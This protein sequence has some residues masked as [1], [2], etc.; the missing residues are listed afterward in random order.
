MIWIFRGNKALVKLKVQTNCL[1]IINGLLGIL[2][3]TGFTVHSMVMDQLTRILYPHPKLNFLLRLVEA[4]MTCS[5]VV[6]DETRLPH[7][8]TLTRKNYHLLLSLRLCSSHFIGLEFH[9]AA[10]QIQH[11]FLKFFAFKRINQLIN[12][13]S[14]NNSL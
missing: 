9:P 12:R 2:C 5:V 14:I 4:F 1:Q 3:R 11:Y 10:L 6:E 7:L 8:I 13:L